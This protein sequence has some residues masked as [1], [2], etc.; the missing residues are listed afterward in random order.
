MFAYCGNNSVTRKDNSGEF[1][2]LVVCVAVICPLVFTS[3]GD[4][5]ESLVGTPADPAP[6][7]TRY[8]TEKEA[9]DAAFAAVAAEYKKE[10]NKGNNVEHICAVYKY[11][12]NYYLGDVLPGKEWGSVE[13]SKD[14]NV[15][16][17][18]H[19]H[20]LA[21]GS[22]FSAE[23]LN[24]AKDWQRDSYVLVVGQVNEYD[25]DKFYL[26]YKASNCGQYKKYYTEGEISD[27]SEMRV[28]RIW[29][30]WIHETC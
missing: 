14:R 29:R 24:V 1:W 21:W 23:D 25:H 11:G 19:T 13:V 9:V 10:S 17:E 16:A 5:N 18:V 26:S 22:L 8:T 4:P 2:L 6:K 30:Y 20:P 27:E 3:C 28:P 12:D 15:V 7:T